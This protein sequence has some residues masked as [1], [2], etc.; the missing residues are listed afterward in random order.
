MITV[1]N[2]SRYLS[3]PLDS[4]RNT[5]GVMKKRRLGATD[6]APGEIGIGTSALSAV[7]MAAVPDAELR[8]TL[9]V[10]LD[11]QA[12]LIDV[13]CT[14]GEDR[15]L[16]QL[17]FAMRDRRRQVLVCLR[18]AGDPAE[19]RIHAEAALRILDTDHVDLL[20]WDHPAFARLRG[21]DAA[22]TALAALKKEGKARALGVSLDRPEEL[23]AAMEQ[24]PVEVLQFPLSVVDQSNIPVLDAAQGKGLG[25]IATKPLDSGWLSGRFGAHH[26]F[27]D[28]RRRWSHG[29]K[30]RRAA[31]QKSFESLAL[32][33]GTAAAQAALQFALSFPQ[34]GC[35]VAGVS[36]WQQLVG[37][38][39]A[40]WGSLDPSVVARLRSLWADGFQERPVAP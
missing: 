26:V 25:L 5:Q 1:T 30:A 33:S 27:M 31:F 38:V 4:A 24:S 2:H 21:R 6:L 28:S 9:G 16:R 35:V 15:A 22:W 14:G 17:G 18:V 23:R 39:D 34:I 29:D 11:M 37:N 13:A 19:L 32:K 7:G 12:S 10:A 20:L 40:S 8:Y 36:A 3:S